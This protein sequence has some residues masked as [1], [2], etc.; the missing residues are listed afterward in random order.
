[1][2]VCLIDRRGLL[3]TFSSVIGV[4]VRPVAS[5]AADL[6]VERRRLRTGPCGCSCSSSSLFTLLG[7]ELTPTMAVKDLLRRSFSSSVSS[8]RLTLTVVSPVLSEISPPV[9]KTADSSVLPVEFCCWLLA[10]RPGRLL[11][12]PPPV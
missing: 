3:L 7:D 12:E 11:S 10:M 1:M 5:L 4:S 6:S 2:E 9:R 8:L